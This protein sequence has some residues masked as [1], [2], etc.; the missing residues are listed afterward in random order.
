MHAHKRKREKRERER[1]R[2]RERGQKEGEER[3]KGDRPGQTEKDRQ[4]RVVTAAICDRACFKDITDFKN[5]IDFV[6][7]IAWGLLHVFL[8]L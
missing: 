4:E 7:P 5:L 1:E 2:E 8:G 3:G 6:L